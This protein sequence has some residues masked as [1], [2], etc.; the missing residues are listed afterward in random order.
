MA[1]TNGNVDDIN[2]FLDDYRGGESH[3]ETWSPYNQAYN[4]SVPRGYYLDDEA[5]TSGP[6]TTTWDQESN[7]THTTKSSH[8]TQSSRAHTARSASVFSRRSAATQSSVPST[9]P[10]RWT[11][12]A[13][14]S[15]AGGNDDFVLWCE[16]R[17]LKGCETT[18]RGDDEAAWIQHH[19]RHLRE[20]LPNELVCWFCDD[21]PRFVAGGTSERQS[22]FE[23][24]M[25]HVRRHILHDGYWTSDQMRPDFFMVSHMYQSGRLDKN[26]YDFAMAYTEV[27]ES[28]RQPEWDESRASKSGAVVHDLEKERR[29]HKKRAGRKG[30]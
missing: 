14:M 29:H 18:F 15:Q 16:F 13:G 11:A 25:E 10:A 21:H 6:S 22:N 26:M 9:A 8:K 1:N 3:E 7:Y 28:L 4:Y 20:S 23:D 2:Q 12:Y 19:I 24:R 30:R 27:P 5:S 17:Q